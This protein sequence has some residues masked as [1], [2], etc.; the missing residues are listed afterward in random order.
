M[1]RPSRHSRRDALDYVYDKY[2]ARDPQAQAAL[3]AA[4]TSAQIARQIYDLRTKAGLTQAQLAKLV[5]TTASVICQL[6]DADYRGRTLQLLQRVAAAL[7]RTV[8]VRLVPMQARVKKR[9]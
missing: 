7:Q 6:E 8:Q 3:E 4:R 2:I 9:P 1:A 5:G